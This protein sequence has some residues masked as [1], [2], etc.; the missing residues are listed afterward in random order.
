VGTGTTTWDLSAPFPNP[1][2]VGGGVTLPL[3]VPAAGPYDATIEIQDGAGQLVRKLSLR[4]VAPGPLS[5]VWD[6]R[7]E[8]G[9]P[10]RP[11]STARG[12]EPAR[13]ASSYAS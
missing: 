3:E 13:P 4:G 5:L 10:P 9:V 12:C 8:P 6:G 2:P 11:V 1:S 7:N